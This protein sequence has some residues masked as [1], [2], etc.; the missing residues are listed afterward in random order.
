MN[1]VK[2]Y[3]KSYTPSSMTYSLLYVSNMN[4]IGRLFNLCTF[5]DGVNSEYPFPLILGKIVDHICM[6]LEEHALKFYLTFSATF[7]KT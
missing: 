7:N 4:K 1:R 6:Q 2:L 3:L 5:L